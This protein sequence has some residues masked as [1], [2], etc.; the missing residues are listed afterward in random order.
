MRARDLRRRW[1][2]FNP[3]LIN[4]RLVDLLTGRASRAERAA[5]ARLGSAA[6]LSKPR[7]NLRDLRLLCVDDGLR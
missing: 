4:R 1:A 3:A 6:F 5:F 7:T 2:A